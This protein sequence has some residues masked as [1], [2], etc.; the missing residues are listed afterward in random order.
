MTRG[1]QRDVDRARAAA[2]NAGG[3]TKQEGSP[4]QRRENDAAALQ[5]K[6][7]K[8]KEDAE[9]IARGESLPQAKK[10]VCKFLLI[11]ILC[12][13][14]FNQCINYFLFRICIL[15]YRFKVRNLVEGRKNNNSCK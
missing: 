14:S 15:K 10:I 3:G 11:N 4:L 13:I 1:N 6:L 12:I 2:R 7:L 5:A 8:K 9:K